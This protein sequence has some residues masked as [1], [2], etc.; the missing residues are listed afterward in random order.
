MTPDYPPGEW[1]ALLV[2]LQW[3]S[4]TTV[5]IL[6]NALANRNAIVTHFADLYRTLQEA[7]NTTLCKQE[8]VTADA[9]RDAF[10]QGADQASEVVRKNQAYADALQKA[11]N[12]VVTLRGA[13]TDIAARGNN[14][15]HDIQ[16]SKADL[17]TKVTE[18]TEAIA[19]YQ[20][21]ANEKAAACADD[22]MGAGEGVV[23]AQGGTGQ[24]FRGMAHAAGLDGN[25][26]PDLKAIEDHVR[27][28]LNQPAPPGAA[29]APPGGPAAS[30]P[31]PTAPAAPPP[32][33]P[34]AGGAA[35]NMPQPTA[36]AAPPPAA[37]PAGG[38]AANMP[39]PTAPV[40]AA[41]AAFGGNVPTAAPGPPPMSTMPS[42]PMGGM[43]HQRVSGRR[44]TQ[45]QAGAAGLEYRGA[46]ECPHISAGRR[47]C[48]GGRCS[49]RAH[50]CRRLRLPSLRQRR[51]HR[52]R[53]GTPLPRRSRRPHHPCHPRRWPTPPSRFRP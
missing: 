7:I 50:R 39:Q 34:P 32:A 33:A 45:Q 35:A 5:E 31:Q 4:G 21:E 2:G 8:G 48:P 38:A 24:S 26:Q 42:A 11:V 25:Q 3:V 43:A 30:M 40:P 36:P 18:I 47:V 13:L 49:D 44:L 46:D 6:D 16:N 23:T 27:G 52:S 29:P 20:R 10:R 1:S 17:A 22:I 53:L 41:P 51:A 12:A 37:P 9:I 28:Q 14:E 15:I 19:K